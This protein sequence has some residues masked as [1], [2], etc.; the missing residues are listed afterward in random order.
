VRVLDVL[1]AAVLLAV[2]GVWLAPVFGWWRSDPPVREF[3]VDWTSLE[4]YPGRSSSELIEPKR[5]VPNRARDHDRNLERIP[6]IEYRPRLE[7]DS[8]GERE[9]PETESASSEGALDPQPLSS[10]TPEPPETPNSGQI[11]PTTSE[12]EPVELATE[13]VGSEDPEP[14]EVAPEPD[15]SE[16]DTSGPVGYETWMKVAQCESGGN[17][18][19]TSANGLYYGGLQFAPSSWEWVGG[20]GMP[21]QASK[22]EQI[23]RAQELWRRQGWQA[24]PACSRILGLR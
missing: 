9:D 11:E 22:A 10:P 3:E 17:W 1:R 15:A 16:W 21:H 12:L 2:V 20:S 7:D 14:E 23:H 5:R 8:S 13:P 19:A 6:D 18:Q 24:W 4:T